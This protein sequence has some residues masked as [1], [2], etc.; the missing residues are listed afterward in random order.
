MLLITFLNSSHA[1]ALNNYVVPA[2]KNHMKPT[3]MDGFDSTGLIFLGGGIAVTII[4]RQYDEK[5]ASYFRRKSILSE[6][7]TEFGNWLAADGHMLILS[8]IHTVINKEKGLPHFESYLATGL[9]VELMKNT[10]HRTRPDKVGEQS[11][12]SG[13][14]AVVFASATA[15]TY[16]Y[17][18][19]AAL[20]AFSLAAITFFS[21][22]ESHKHFLSDVVLGSVIGFFWARSASLHHFKVTPVVSIDSQGISFSTNF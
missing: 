8:S 1:T 7:M 4:A 13:D 12:P 3:A 9:T 14:V 11:I 6:D 15:L 17:G 21:R 19:K 16:G 5:V 2:Y 10:M 20:P 22:M 18:I